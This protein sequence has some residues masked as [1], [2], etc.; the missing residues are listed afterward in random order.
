MAEERS[1]F[2]DL[3]CRR[4]ALDEKRNRLRPFITA[5]S[6]LLPEFE[7]SARDLTL[8]MKTLEKI[9]CLKK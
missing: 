4:L 5:V 2:D 8:L 6:E 3:P 1:P 9:P 7:K